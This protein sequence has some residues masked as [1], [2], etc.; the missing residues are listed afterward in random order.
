MVAD[1]EIN[2]LSSRSDTVI[3]F[4]LP[5]MITSDML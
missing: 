1:E 2:L 4:I 5:E 3:L